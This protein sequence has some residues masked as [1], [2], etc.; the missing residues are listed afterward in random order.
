MTTPTFQELLT[1][2]EA[3]FTNEQLE[4]LIK[5]YP[6]KPLILG[7]NASMDHYETTVWER[8]V[9]AMLNRRADAAPA[10]ARALLAERKAREV[11]VG[12]LRAAAEDLVSLCSADVKM[13]GTTYQ[14]MPYRSAFTKAVERMI[15]ALKGPT[16]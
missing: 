5:P 3:R 11:E 4:A 10:L 12:E 15:E 2:Q 9:E 14:P 1:S 16:P 7:G 13:N 6:A 8:T